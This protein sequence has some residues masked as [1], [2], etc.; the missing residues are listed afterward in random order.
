MPI[1]TPFR[2]ANSK[3]YAHDNNRRGKDCFV[4]IQRTES[5]CGVFDDGRQNLEVPPGFASVAVVPGRTRYFFDAGDPGVFTGSIFTDRSPARSHWASAKHMDRCFRWYPSAR[6]SACSI[7]WPRTPTR[8]PVTRGGTPASVSNSFPPGWENSPILPQPMPTQ[9]M[10]R[11]R[12][13]NK[14]SANR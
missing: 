5:G 10:R 13:W 9:P 2:G 11:R 1:L 14:G 3:S 4:I 8:K 6:P 12:R 7:P